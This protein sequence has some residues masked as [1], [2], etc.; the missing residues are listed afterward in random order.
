[1]LIKSSGMLCDGLNLVSLGEFCS[2]VVS[3][4]EHGLQPAVTGASIEAAK[5]LNTTSGTS[6]N[7]NDLIGIS[8]PFLLFD[9][10]SSLHVSSL[11]ERLASQGYALNQLQYLLLTHLHPERASGLPYL[12]RLV[13]EMTVV[14]SRELASA[15]TPK[16]I[17]HFFQ[18]DCE[19]R[20]KF[21]AQLTKSGNSPDQMSA[22][23]Y[24]ELFKID[25]G[26]VDSD[27]LEVD[28]QIKVR[29]VRAAGH[30]AESFCYLVHP[31]EYLIVDETCGYFR[32]QEISAPGFDESIEE[33]IKF[34][35]HLLDLNLGGLC[36]PWSGTLV[37]SLSRKHLS[38]VIQ[39]CEDVAREV[40]R[41][42]SEKY[43]EEHIVT[44]I[45]EGLY[46]SPTP[47]AF[48]KLSLHRSCEEFLKQSLK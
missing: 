20:A 19:W 14:A 17:E 32:G 25:E 45:K 2:Y 43:P 5:P 31:Y 29:A 6:F 46:R 22:Q 8:R 15:V 23:D 4:P 18:Q 30:A 27:I 1:M 3:S 7:S 33:G 37:G 13:P 35:K 48:L 11:T 24:S 9:C 36:L 34:L 41:S 16:L 26:L 10:G 21:G 38:T 39:A 40:T 47:D 44:S 42:R 28:S 12:R